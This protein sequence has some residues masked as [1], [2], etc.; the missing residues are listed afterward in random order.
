[1]L[2]IT[3]SHTFVAKSFGIFFGLMTIV[4]LGYA[5]WTTIHDPQL[6]TVVEESVII[7]I[8]AHVT[9]NIHAEIRGMERFTRDESL[10]RE[11]ERMMGEKQVCDRID[12]PMT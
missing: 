7:L 6:N 3:R 12:C 2:G 5:V 9:H 4:M 1:M 11:V 10:Y 8:L